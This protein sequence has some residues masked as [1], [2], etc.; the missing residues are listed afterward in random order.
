MFFPKK[1]KTQ[2][3]IVVTA[4]VAFFP[5]SYMAQG[6]ATTNLTFIVNPYTGGLL[7]SVPIAAGLGS[8]ESPETVT[9]VTGQLESVTVTD[10]RRGGPL[11]AW[12]ASAISTDLITGTD[13]LTATTIGYSAGLPTV[14]SG[15]AGVT[16]LTQND[17][18]TTQPVQKGSSTLGNHIVSWKPK[19]SVG[20]KYQQAAGTYV[21]VLTHSVA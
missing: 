21:G 17:L 7:I 11:R 16:E 6:A 14:V 5:G 20:L 2:L 19:L 15:T 4:L 9:A 18:S 13:S 8:L 10:T 12:T 3:A 1:R